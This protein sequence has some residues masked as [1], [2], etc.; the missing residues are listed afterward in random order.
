MQFVRRPDFLHDGIPTLGWLAEQPGIVDHYSGVT[1]PYW[2][3]KLFCALSLSDESPF[4][5]ARE[6]EGFWPDP[7][8]RYDIGRTGMW[9]D[10]DARTGHSRLHAPQTAAPGDVRYSARYFDTADAS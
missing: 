8:S 3:A 4:W 9:V 5:T 1:S 6:N 2:C 7:P 10:H